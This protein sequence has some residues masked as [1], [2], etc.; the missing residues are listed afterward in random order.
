MVYH[1]L[2][3]LYSRRIRQAV[4]MKEFIKDPFIRDIILMVVKTIVVSILLM[5]AQDMT[6]AVSD[7]LPMI[8]GAFLIGRS[9]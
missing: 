7:I 3:I 9:L 8:F 2:G 6:G 5:L 1:A 4:I